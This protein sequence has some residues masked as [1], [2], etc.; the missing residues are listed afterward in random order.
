M[1]PHFKALEAAYQLHFYLCFKTQYLKPLLA[2]SETHS[3]VRE[4]LADVC[5][6]QHYHLLETEITADH[7]RLLVS[8][9]PS[10]TVSETAKMVK[11]NLD[12][13]SL[14]KFPHVAP[15]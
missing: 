5:Q 13:Q 1:N 4:T 6:R 3:L 12:H 9:Q 2:S 15:T 8:L 10:Q 14:S 11:G 7:L